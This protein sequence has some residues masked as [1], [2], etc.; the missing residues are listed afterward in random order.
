MSTK[1]PRAYWQTY[2]DRNDGPAGVAKKLGIP[3]QTIASVCNGSRG[4][5]HD[6][7]DRMAKADKSLDK[8]VLVWVRPVAKPKRKRAA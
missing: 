4:I 2:V 7:A 5:G 6:L 3:Y 8:S 1:D